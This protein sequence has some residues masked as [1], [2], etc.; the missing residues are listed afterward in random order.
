MSGPL[1][2]SIQMPL[3]DQDFSIYAAQPEE[4]LSMGKKIPVI[5]SNALPS[6]SPMPPPRKFC[7]AS[8]RAAHLE[9]VG[10]K[11]SS[12]LPSFP[13]LINRLDSCPNFEDEYSSPFSHFALSRSIPSSSLRFLDNKLDN[14]PVGD[15]QIFRDGSNDSNPA[16]LAFA[17]QANG[18]SSFDEKSPISASFF[19]TPQSFPTA[20][21]GELF[22][23]NEDCLDPPVGFTHLPSSED[24]ATSWKS[25]SSTRS[26]IG[27]IGGLPNSSFG[28]SSSSHHLARFQQAS[29]TWGSFSRERFV[30]LENSFSAKISRLRHTDPGAHARGAST[31][32]RDNYIAPGSRSSGKVSSFNEAPETPV[33]KITKTAIENKSRILAGIS[34]VIAA[35]TAGPAIAAGSVTLSVGVAL[36]GAGVTGTNL[37][38]SEVSRQNAEKLM[39]INKKIDKLDEKIKENCKLLSSEID[40]RNREQLDIEIGQ[41]IRQYESLKDDQE[42]LIS[43]LTGLKRGQFGLS[44]AGLLPLGADPTQIINM[45]DQISTVGNTVTILGWGDDALA[46]Y[47]SE[48]NKNEEQK[49]RGPHS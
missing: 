44:C 22:S 7:P 37:I 11:G 20:S 43:R 33:S 31:V 28:S 32:P 49:A 45:A 14:P 17:K 2:K 40:E 24:L 18:S 23:P 4:N 21:L 36:Y 30:G 3:A 39:E 8:M 34:L 41:M 48:V 42:N 35:V 12:N 26:S 5:A 15:D 16:S 13:M 19:S 1:A 47:D 29:E 38:L 27:E 25:F 6:S 9:N 10:L 46:L